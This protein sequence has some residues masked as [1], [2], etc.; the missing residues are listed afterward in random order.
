M[1][2]PCTQIITTTLTPQ[3]LAMANGTDSLYFSPSSILTAG[4]QDS[5]VKVCIWLIPAL[6]ILRAIL[7]S[8]TSSRLPPGPPRLPIIGHLH[9]LAPIPHQALYKLAVKYGPLYHI[10]LG[11]NP[12]V[13][14]SSPEMAKEFLK[15][16]EL[17][18]SNRPES[19]ASEYLSYH[20]QDFSYAPY[21]PYWRFVKKLCMSELLSGQS[22]DFLH[23]VRR[24]EI[25]SMVKEMLQKARAVE[26]VDVGGVITRI[27]N[28]VISNM[29]MSKRC[30]DTDDE[31][32]E[33]RKMIKE[34]SKLLG[35][36][37]PADYV[38]F[39][40][41]LDLQRIKK[42]LVDVRARYDR[43]AQSIIDER[44]EIRKTQEKIAADKDFLDLLLDVYEDE[45][46][47]FRLNMDKIKA[48]ILV[49]TNFYL[50]QQVE[51]NIGHFGLILTIGL[52]RKII[53]VRLGTWISF[54]ILNL[55]K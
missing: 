44:R 42:R 12:C 49:N 40:K 24:F 32:G 23:T 20:S 11:N 7:K 6:I 39:Y 2:V 28:N 48:I 1:Q 9:L 8:R 25:E 47:E 3:V 38:W 14:I 46:A 41:F 36:F 34:I 18:C 55:K 37:N 19:M 33:M 45:K 22:L 26:A 51:I 10:Y 54:E 5:V 29:I 17:S 35:E 13:I 30:S 31:A 50:P 43:L 4:F 15:T 16:N 52:H 53:M 21:G 27:T